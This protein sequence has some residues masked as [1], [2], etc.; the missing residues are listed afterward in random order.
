M[1][2]TA[3]LVA[4][5]QMDCSSRKGVYKDERCIEVSDKWNP[6]IVS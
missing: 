1:Y 3:V 5:Y 4:F 2:N 6:A